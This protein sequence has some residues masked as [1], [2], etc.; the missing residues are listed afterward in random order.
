[1]RSEVTTMSALTD[2]NEHAAANLQAHALADA[3]RITE[4]QR[5]DDVIAAWFR[6]D[7]ELSAYNPDAVRELG[8]HTI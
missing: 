7:T 2:A 4:Q 5:V 8:R 6:R 1:M 3:H